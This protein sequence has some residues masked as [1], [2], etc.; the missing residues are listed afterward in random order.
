M[1]WKRIEASREVRLWVSQII[2]PAATLGAV[3]LSNDNVR[4]KLVEMK[5]QVHD[6]LASLKQK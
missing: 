3:I 5:N 1:S 6:K 2:I 4:T